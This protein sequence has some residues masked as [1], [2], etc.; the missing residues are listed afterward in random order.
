MAPL[1]SL[2]RTLETPL[3]RNDPMESEGLDHWPNRMHLRWTRAN[4]TDPAGMFSRFDP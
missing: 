4:P 1:D 2:I 3:R